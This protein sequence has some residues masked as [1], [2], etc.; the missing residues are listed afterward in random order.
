MADDL[1]QLDEWFGRILAGLD[2]AQ[3]K[4]AATKLGEA[5]RRSNLKRIAE[6]V[7]P[8]G[9]AM[10]KRKPR[11]DRRGRLRAKAGAMFRR[12]RMAKN[13]KID[14]D[15]DGVELGFKNASLER[16]AAIHHFGEVG[17]VGKLRDGRTIRT[18]YAA[19][20]L[21]G[22]SDEDRQLSID[23]AAEMLDASP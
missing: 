6:N 22:F 19:R 14:A 15:A 1:Q 21:L 17:L 10:E 18:R 4:R 12:L 11:Q 9:G 13:F 20:R 7:E 5:L 3:R 16:V 8:D 23:I 2:P